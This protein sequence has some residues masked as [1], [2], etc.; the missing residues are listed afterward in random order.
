LPWTIRAVNPPGADAALRAR[1][2]LL[3]SSLGALLALVVVGA[4]FIGRSVARELAVSQLQSDF[5]STVSHELRTPLTAL[6]Q[7]SELLTRGRVASEQDRQA[8]YAHLYNESDRLRRLAEG[9]LNFSRL[10]AGR[11]PFQFERLDPAAVVRQSVEEFNAAQP[12]HHRLEIEHATTPP[13]RADRDALRCALWNLL[14][15]AVK[16]SPDADVVRI[17]VASR[18]RH[19]EISIEDRGLGISRQ[20]R[21]RIFE[22]FVRGSASRD[23]SIRGTGI[24]LAMVRQIVRAH[25]GKVTIESELGHGSTFRV[26]LPQEESA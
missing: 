4:G 17:A 16:Y 3:V 6:Y 25:G 18:G 11:M 13:V 12:R 23:R 2:L 14:D 19:V 22:R 26:F 21:R 9:L 15:N 5:V 1:R 20:E 24:G 8:Y 7:L 10:D